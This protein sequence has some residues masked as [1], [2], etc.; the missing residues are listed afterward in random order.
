MWICPWS[1]CHRQS[2]SPHHSGCF[3]PQLWKQTIWALTCFVSVSLCPELFGGEKS[4]KL[5]F[6]WSYISDLERLALSGQS[7]VSSVQNRAIR[8]TQQSKSD[9]ALT[10]IEKAALFCNCHTDMNVN[11]Y[12]TIWKSKLW[13]GQKLEIFKTHW[14]WFWIIFKRHVCPDL[15]I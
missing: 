8:S 12:Q 7:Q 15:K 1:P 2:C 5:T 14:H 11:R 3:S 9:I 13:R 10:D 6:N 4:V